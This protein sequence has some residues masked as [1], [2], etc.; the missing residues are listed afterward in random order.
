VSVEATPESETSSVI[1]LDA[2]SMLRWSWPI[3]PRSRRRRC[4]SSSTR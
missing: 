1:G 4:C 2:P 3:R